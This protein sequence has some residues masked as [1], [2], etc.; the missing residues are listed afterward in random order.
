[1]ADETTRIE[2]WLTGK[3]TG[4]TT[5]AN[6]IGAPG[7]VRVHSDHAPLASTWPCVVFQ[8][9]GGHDVG[10]GTRESNRIMLDGLWVVKGI[11]QQESYGGTL[12]SI[13]D[14]ID[15]LLQNSTGGAAGADG[16]VFAAVREQPFRLAEVDDGVEYRHLGGM[17]RIWGQVP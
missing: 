5:L 6:L 2:T 10:G 13:A 9:Q 17:Y 3:L 7:D 8:Y 16:T 14:R 12:K 4:D 11:A 15:A 1:M